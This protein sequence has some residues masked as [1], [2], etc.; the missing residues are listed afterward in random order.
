MTAALRHPPFC[1]NASLINVEVSAY[2]GRVIRIGFVGT[3][4]AGN[5][6]YI[7]DLSLTAK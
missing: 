5:N 1:H 3:S 6:L 4:G 2:L 7:D